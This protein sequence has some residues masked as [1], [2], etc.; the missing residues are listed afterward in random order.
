MPR[1]TAHVLLLCCLVLAG[2]LVVGPGAAVAHECWPADQPPP[3]YD[4]RREQYWSDGDQVCRD[5]W[6]VPNWRENY[7]PLF[8]LEDRHD[9]EQR[10]DAQRWRTECNPRTNEYQQMC[11]WNYGGFSLFPDP[12]D[13]G[14]A[15]NEWHVG[16]AATHCFLFEAAHQ[17]EDH[18]STYGEGVHD[19]HGG[20]IYVDVCLSPNPES[21][22]CRRGIEDT[23]AGVTIVDH[24]GCVPAGC[25]DEY[26]VV[27]P[28]DTAY[29]QRQLANSERELRFNAAHPGHYVCGHHRN[30]YDCR[31]S[32]EPAEQVTGLVLDTQRDRTD[33]ERGCPNPPAAGYVDIAGDPHA[34]AIG[35]AAW[36]EAVPA[37]GDG[38]P[39]ERFVPERLLTRAEAAAW[40]VGFVLR[41]EGRA[42]QPWDGQNHFDDVWHSS[43]HMV[44][45]NRVAAAGIMAPVEPNR[46]APARP[47]TRAELAGHLAAAIAY[48]TGRDRLRDDDR[49]DDVAADHPHRRALNG[50]AHLGIVLGPDGGQAATVRPD[51]V[52]RRAETAALLMRGLD[53]HVEEGWANPPSSRY[54]AHGR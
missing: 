23:Q 9:P 30:G 13:P 48:V 43:T 15:P 8:G 2:V 31:D 44:A 10:A 22:Y 25:F 3:D 36:W 12:G 14:N 17:C 20:A 18:A 21:R 16:F 54:G 29:T 1:R 38:T 6:I 24:L 39:P 27:R 46:F 28:L 40:L 11:M 7:V 53:L 35:C 33:L 52:V 47:V 51:E 50:L 42:V 32:V 4:E 49:F 34:V 45:V 26:H 5:A 41:S 37:H 19:T